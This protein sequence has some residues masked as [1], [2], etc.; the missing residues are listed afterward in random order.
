HL[1]LYFGHGVHETSGGW[2]DALGTNLA[3]NV[4]HPYLGV[5]DVLL[6]EK[7]PLWVVLIGCTTGL[8]SEETGDVE[9]MGMAQAFLARGSRWAVASVREVQPN[10]AVELTERLFLLGL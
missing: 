4:M 7:A 3:P 8:S 9:G 5:S 1:F 2:Y 10:N 6:M